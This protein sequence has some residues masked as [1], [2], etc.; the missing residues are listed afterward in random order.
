M[1]N[2]DIP[3]SEISTYTARQLKESGDKTLA[4][5]VDKLWGTLRKLPAEKEKLF[6]DYRKKLTPGLIKKAD[7][8]MGRQHFQRLCVGCHQMFGEGGTVGPELT[9]SQRTNLDYLLE[10]LI[11]PSAAVSKDYQLEIIETKSGRVVAGVITSET[12]TTI[13]VKSIN[14]EIALSV[15]EIKKRTRSPV[16]MMPEGLLQTLTTEQALELIAYL[17]SPRQV[18]LPAQ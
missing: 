3:L 17:S 8:G 15:S 1:E 5:R 13:K 10:N 16:S 7:P 6:A 2:E 18:A 9:G 4:K 14:E 12:D 11:D